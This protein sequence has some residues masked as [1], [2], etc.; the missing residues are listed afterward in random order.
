MDEVVH[1]GSM[2]TGRVVAC[3]YVGLIFDE[4]CGYK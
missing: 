2:H 4:D 3:V 1:M